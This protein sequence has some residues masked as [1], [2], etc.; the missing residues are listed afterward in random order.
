[1]RERTWTFYDDIVHVQASAYAHFETEI[2]LIIVLRRHRTRKFGEITQ[3]MAITPFK[4]IQGHRF[5]YQWKAHVYDFLLV[6]NTNLLPILLRFRDIA[7]NTSEI[8]IFGYPSCVLCPRW[9]GFLHHII[10]SDISL[11][12]RSFGLHFCRRNFGNIFN[13]FYTVRP[14]TYR[15]R[16]NNAK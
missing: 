8:A 13:H 9:R 4:V 2:G 6:I 10:V 11:K 14:E 7:F 15:I 3:I 12:T 16:Q 1:M 5:W